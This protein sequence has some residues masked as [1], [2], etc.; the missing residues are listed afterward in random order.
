MLGLYIKKGIVVSKINDAP[1]W[2]A[3]VE[4]WLCKLVITNQKTGGTFCGSSKLCLNN[5]KYEFPLRNAPLCFEPFYKIAEEALSGLFLNRT[6]F[7]QQPVSPLFRY[8]STEVWDEDDNWSVSCKEG[9][10]RQET[11]L[12][13]MKSFEGK[14]IPRKSRSKKKT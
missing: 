11:L 10:A 13:Y 5:R 7:G 3:D 12:K 14:S 4:S 9:L 8:L 1:V 6:D 2:E